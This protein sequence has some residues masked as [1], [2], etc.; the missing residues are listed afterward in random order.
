MKNKKTVT[1][2]VIIA[3]VVTLLFVFLPS[4]FYEVKEDEY[5]CTARFSKI[6]RTVDQP[7]LYF[8][9]PFIDTVR[10]Y[11]KKTLFYDIPPS[12]VLTVDKKSM[13]VDSYILWRI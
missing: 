13:T 10:T 3:A 4:C 11:P 2:I 5:A 8:K 12:E 9:L 6:I 7:G 1:I